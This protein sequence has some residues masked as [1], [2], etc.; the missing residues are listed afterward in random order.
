[1]TWREAHSRHS[2]LFHVSTRQVAVFLRNCS[3]NTR[4][5][6]RL[7]ARRAS[8]VR[9]RAKPTARAPR[10][11]AR[12]ARLDQPSG[13]NAKRS[14]SCSVMLM[15][16]KINARRRVNRQCIAYHNL[17]HDYRNLKHHQMF[18]LGKTQRKKYVQ[19][20]QDTKDKSTLW[21]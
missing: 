12:R 10:Q 11:E 13:N 16:C 2:N 15:M 6:Q 14:D 8:L 4:R 18:K 21:G 7:G 9:Q 20:R 17:Q 1:M 3:G 19:M 5:T